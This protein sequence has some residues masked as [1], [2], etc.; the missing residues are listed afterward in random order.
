[1]IVTDP[2]P[3]VLGQE[4]PALI[5]DGHT[6][7]KVYMTYDALRLDDRQALDVLDP[8]RREGAGPDGTRRK[9]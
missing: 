3:Q 1:M 4:L 6:S 7:I 5:R 2:T 8:A 9:P